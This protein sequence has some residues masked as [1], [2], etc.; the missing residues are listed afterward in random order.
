MSPQIKVSYNCGCCINIRN[1]NIF[2]MLSPCLAVTITIPELRLEFHKSQSNTLMYPFPL[3]F[4]V[5]K[6]RAVFSKAL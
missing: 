2:L 6:S 1:R 3:S 4:S 5:V